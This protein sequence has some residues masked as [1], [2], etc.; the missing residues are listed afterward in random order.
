MKSIFKILKNNKYDFS[1]FILIIVNLIILTVICDEKIFYPIII[2]LMIIW[3]MICVIESVK[4][5][6]KSKEF[7]FY[8]IFKLCVVIS[9]MICALI[10]K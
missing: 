8:I 1:Y 7:K 6:N 5:K 9:L 3:F 2:T 4:N 10:L